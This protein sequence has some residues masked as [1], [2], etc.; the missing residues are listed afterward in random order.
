MS[1]HHRVIG[2]DLGTTFS[3]VAA[4][5]FDKQEVKV[6]RVVF[7]SLNVVRYARVRMGLV[8]TALTRQLKLDA[9]LAYEI[10]FRF[11]RIRQL[12]FFLRLLFRLIV[13]KI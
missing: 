11:L 10:P 2:I 4:W 1:D 9:V 3:V 13:A 7:S 5:H 8:L 6:L 12:Q